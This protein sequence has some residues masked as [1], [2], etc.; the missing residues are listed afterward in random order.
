MSPEE[1]QLEIG[2]LPEKWLRK[3]T[4]KVVERGPS[5][6]GMSP[7]KWPARKE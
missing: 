5:K 7:E 4:K 1:G 3:V 6:R 2:M